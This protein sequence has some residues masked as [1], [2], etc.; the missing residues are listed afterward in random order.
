MIGLR[1]YFY[2]AGKKTIIKEVQE[3]NFEYYYFST[4]DDGVLAVVL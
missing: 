2:E 3:V 1:L 4:L